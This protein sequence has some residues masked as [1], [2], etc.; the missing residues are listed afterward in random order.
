L[1]NLLPSKDLFNLTSDTK[2]KVGLFFYIKTYTPHFIASP[3]P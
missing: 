3:I 1:Q 2:I